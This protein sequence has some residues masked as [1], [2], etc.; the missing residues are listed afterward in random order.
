MKL[1]KGFVHLGAILI[2][3]GIIAVLVVLFSKHAGVLGTATTISASSTSITASPNPCALNSP[4]TTCWTTISWT[5]AQGQTADICVS[6]NG[7]SEALFASVGKAGSKS[8]SWIYDSAKYT[9]NLRVPSGMF[10]IFGGT[11]CRGSIA[12]SVNTTAL[13]PARKYTIKQGVLVSD[14]HGSLTPYLGATVNLYKSG[15]STFLL[16]AKTDKEG[17]VNFDVLPG[18]YTVELIVPSGYYANQEFGNKRN[19]TITNNNDLYSNF[20]IYTQNTVSIAASPP[21]CKIPAKGQ[22][23]STTIK[24]VLASGQTADI[25]TRINYETNYSLFTTVSGSGSKDTN[26]IAESNLYT[27]Y[28]MSPAGRGGATCTGQVLSSAVAT[29]KL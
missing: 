29:G 15:E 25:C 20:L 4:K 27:F 5:L 10:W 23:C 7:G 24:W 14:N 6:V 2:S 13:L 3:I 9:F 1:F 11:K 22:N 21:T 16:T 17:S 18:N 19:V 26:M 12:A 28:L 8:A